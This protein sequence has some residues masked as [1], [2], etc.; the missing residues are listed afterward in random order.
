[1]IKRISLLLTAALLVAMLALAGVAAPAFAGTPA[2]E[3]AAA[4]KPNKYECQGNKVV[5]DKNN[6]KHDRVIAKETGQ[7]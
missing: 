3:A 1:V 5:Q 6:P 7:P 2:C 4:Q